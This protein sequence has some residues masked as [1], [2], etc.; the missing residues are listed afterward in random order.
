MR[1]F[2]LVCIF[3]FFLFLPVVSAFQIYNAT[4]YTDEIGHWVNP[5][6]AYS[7]DDVRASSSITEQVTSWHNYSIESVIPVGAVIDDV[8]VYVEHYESV[9]NS[10]NDLWVSNNFGATWFDNA[11]IGQKVNPPDLLTIKTMDETFTRADLTNDTFKT[12]LR[13][14]LGGCYPNNSYMVGFNQKGGWSIKT[15]D[16][17][18]IGDN[19]LVWTDQG[20]FDNRSVRAINEHYGNWTLYNIWSGN[21]LLDPIIDGATSHLWQSHTEV[22]GEH[23]VYIRAWDLEN[24]V[25]IGRKHTKYDEIAHLNYGTTILY[26]AIWRI[27]VR[28]FEGW[29]Y[30]VKVDQEDPY[31]KVYMFSKTLTDQELSFLNNIGYTLEKQVELAP[32]YLIKAGKTTTYV[33]W[34]GVNVTWHTTTTTTTTTLQPVAPPETLMCDPKICYDLNARVI[35]NLPALLDSCNL[36]D[37]YPYFLIFNKHSDILWQIVC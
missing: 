37:W 20:G 3:S 19:M 24:G 9:G 36:L 31:E 6:N 10:V 35:K 8:Y 2:S 17:I 14:H 22:T 13:H 4:D 28:Q 15:P 26:E 12:A 11:S 18:H 34:I 7:S 21:T 5:A 30:D 29:V 32:P 25:W 1:R 33:D 23:P 27:D 16:Q